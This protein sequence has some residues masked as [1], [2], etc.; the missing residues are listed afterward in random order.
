MREIKV[1]VSAEIDPND[2]RIECR[3]ASAYCVRDLQCEEC[4][5]NNVSRSLSEIIY[6]YTV[7]RASEVNA[8]VNNAAD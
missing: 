4:P 3:T 7:L 6:M 1:T 8:E 5:F 2:I